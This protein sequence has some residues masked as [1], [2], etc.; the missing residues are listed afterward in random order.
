MIFL[1]GTL[2]CS[3]WKLKITVKQHALFQRVKSQA[4]ESDRKLQYLHMWENKIAKGY[5]SL[6]KIQE[7]ELKSLI[8]GNIGHLGR[9]GSNMH[10]KFYVTK[11]TNCPNTRTDGLSHIQETSTPLTHYSNNVRVN[12]EGRGDLP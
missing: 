10:T 5:F 1:V 8:F 9:R 4:L 11:F 3:Q 6:S 2:Q 12:V 7:F